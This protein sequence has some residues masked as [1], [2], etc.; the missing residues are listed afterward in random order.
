MSSRII[1][2]EKTLRICSPDRLRRTS[3]RRSSAKIRTVAGSALQQR[4]GQRKEPRIT[5]V[6][7]HDGHGSEENM[8]CD[9]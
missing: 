9:L 4:G 7:L 2:D 6:I 5:A 1:R 3:F 8:G